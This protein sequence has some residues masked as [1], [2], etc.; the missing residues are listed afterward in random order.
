MKIG[1]VEQV[2]RADAL[3]IKYGVP[4]IQLM[5][6]AAVAVQETVLEER[7]KEHNSV[8][9]LCGKGNNAGD[10][11]ALASMLVPY[12]SSVS[13]HLLCGNAFSPDAKYYY[14]RL[15]QKVKIVDEFIAADVYVD[16]VFGTGFAGGLPDTV[17]N[18]FSFVNSADALRIAIDVPSGVAGDG[19]QISNNAFCADVTVTFE[20]L[21][22]CHLLCREQCGRVV[23]KNI[24]LHPKAFS[25]N[26]FL[27]EVLEQGSLPTKNDLMHKGSAGT[28]CSVVGSKTYQ[29]AAALSVNASLRSGCGIVVA[30]VPGSVYLP[31]CCKTTS[32]IVVSC[33]ENEAGQHKS[34]VLDELSDQMLLRR[35]TAILVGSGLGVGEDTYAIVNGV[36]GKEV[37]VVVDGDGLR[38]ISKDALIARS[39]ETVLTPHIGEFSAMCGHSVERVLTERFELSRDYAAMHR[40]VLVLKDHFTLITLPDGKQF[41]LN[42]PNAGLAKGGSG[43]VLAGMIASFLAQGLSAEEAA[44]AGLWYHSAAAKEA[45]KE[46]GVY[47]MLP[48]DVISNLYKV[49]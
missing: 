32:A 38:F 30:L 15:D 26:E 9:I 29:G 25:E 23:V 18:I 3:S 10:G 45:V 4:G 40:V 36:L 14:D 20:I 44:K 1:L 28:L 8:C 7:R 43:D 17:A 48:E 39:A 42:Q 6:N 2:R 5:K 31:L 13:V 16:A 33:T 37:P 35:P 22:K 24:G 19:G 47:A 12:F 21:K 34:K 11:F 46:K 41:V 49:L 27:A